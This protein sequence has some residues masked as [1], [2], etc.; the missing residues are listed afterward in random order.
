VTRNVAVV[1]S[2][3]ESLDYQHPSSTVSQVSHTVQIT[4]NVFRSCSAEFRFSWSIAVGPARLAV[5]IGSNHLSMLLSVEMLFGKAA[6]EG[7]RPVYRRKALDVFFCLN[8]HSG[9]RYFRIMWYFISR[10]DSALPATRCG[11]WSWVAHLALLMYLRWVVI[12]IDIQTPHSRCWYMRA[13]T[14]VVLFIKKTK[15]LNTI[16]RWS[17]F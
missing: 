13:V 6:N 7:L 8:Y 14:L 9:A 11:D 10:R 2:I 12:E 3:D 17:I 5:R 4:G 15:R 16:T 1:I